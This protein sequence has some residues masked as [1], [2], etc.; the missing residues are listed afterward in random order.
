MQALIKPA[1]LDGNNGVKR[2]LFH[3]PF[4]AFL[5]R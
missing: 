4:D 1:F 5:T 3:A 2:R